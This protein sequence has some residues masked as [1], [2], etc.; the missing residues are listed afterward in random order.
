MGAKRCIGFFWTAFLLMIFFL[1]TCSYQCVDIDARDANTVG[2]IFF[3]P[4]SEIFN[5]LCRYLLSI[6]ANQTGT[7]NMIHH[8]N[9][10]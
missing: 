4:L 7:V 3:F 6:K 9:S 8:K 2:L 1:V 5:L 10:Q